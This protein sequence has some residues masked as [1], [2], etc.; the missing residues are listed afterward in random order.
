MG[1]I[2]GNPV[3]FAALKKKKA[4][5][6]SALPQKLNLQLKLDL[7]KKSLKSDLGAQQ[8]IRP[9]GLLDPK[10][11]VRPV[12]GQIPDL[13]KEIQLRVEKNNEFW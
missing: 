11:S 10:I 8:L 7:R 2:T 3:D 4:H 12:E 6:G 13:L 9:T 5:G 1:N